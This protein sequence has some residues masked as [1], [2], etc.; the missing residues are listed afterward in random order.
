MPISDGFHKWWVIK[1][2]HEFPS[3]TYLGRARP[4]NNENPKTKRFLPE[5]N[6]QFLRFDNPTPV[7]IPN[8]T[9]NNPPT[10]GSGIVTKSDENFPHKENTM[11]RIPAT[12]NC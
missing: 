11:R 4:I 1:A 8:M 3:F 7:I 12:K 5:C 6:E 10:T 9:K 2:A